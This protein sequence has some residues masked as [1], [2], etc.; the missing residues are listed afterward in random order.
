MERGGNRPTVGWH[1]HEQLL[2]MCAC[3]PGP[4]C[5]S[6][7]LPAQQPLRAEHLPPRLSHLL[8]PQLLPSGFFLYILLISSQISPKLSQSLEFQAPILST[9]LLILALLQLLPACLFFLPEIPFSLSLWVF[10]LHT[11]KVGICPG[12]C[13]LHCSFVGLGPVSC[14]DVSLLL[15]LLAD[16]SWI[17]TATCCQQHGCMA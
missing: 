14:P 11:I 17:L 6:L 2:H 5:L 1:L 10:F 12:L 3:A 8:H 9:Q 16:P 4:L 15:Q 13:S 7:P